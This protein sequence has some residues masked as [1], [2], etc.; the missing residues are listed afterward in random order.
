MQTVK[1]Q[2]LLLTI[3]TMQQDFISMYQFSN[4]DRNINKKVEQHNFRQ[5]SIEMIDLV[6]QCVIYGS[7]IFDSEKL[8]QRTQLFLLSYISEMDKLKDSQPS[9][10]RRRPGTASHDQQ[11]SKKA[12]MSDLD[13][14]LEQINTQNS[15]MELKRPQSIEKTVQN[16]NKDGSNI[17][18]TDNSISL[19]NSRNSDPQN[20]K[21]EKQ[22]N[23]RNNRS[24]HRRRSSSIKS[25][26]MNSFI[27]QQALKIDPKVDNPNQEEIDHFFGIRKTS[28]TK[29]PES[30]KNFV[31]KNNEQPENFEVPLTE[32]APQPVVEQRPSRYKFS[33]QSTNESLP[34]A[35][36]LTNFCSENTFELPEF[37]FEKDSGAFVCCTDFLKQKFRSRHHK[38]RQD[39]K[40]EVCKYILEFCA[41]K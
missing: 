29:R 39:A 15:Q 17:N 27:K 18:L 25:S 36:R 9:N 11:V 40:N 35:T 34:F 32:S 37:I 12:K 7:T 13:D 41:L 1:K 28:K 31:E 4:T 10:I 19:S 20:R 3:K 30:V 8:L 5:S 24:K 26:T 2:N 33:K 23:G 21:R 38:S 16:Q 6:L 14:L 22:N